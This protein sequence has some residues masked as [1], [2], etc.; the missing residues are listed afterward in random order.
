[1]CYD[2]L[3]VCS[4]CAEYPCTCKLEFFGR[5]PQVLDPAEQIVPMDETHNPNGELKD[6]YQRESSEDSE[7]CR[8]EPRD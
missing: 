7:G 1:M 4:F 5:E 2:G 8:T 6:G 3:H